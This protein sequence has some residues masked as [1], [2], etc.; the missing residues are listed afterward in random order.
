MKRIFQK[1]KGDLQESL[2]KLDYC[3]LF[4]TIDQLK[5]K[6]FQNTCA[7]LKSFS[8]IL[9]SVQHCH[10]LQNF[11]ITSSTSFDPNENVT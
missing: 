4:P 1:N 2:L 8:W 3:I 11:E 9:T 5:E 6:K 7:N 10:S